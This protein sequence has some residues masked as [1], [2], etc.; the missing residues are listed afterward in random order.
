VPH[1]CILQYY[2]NS[3]S[4][5]VLPDVRVPLLAIN[6]GDDPIVRELP[7]PAHN[8][9]VALHV[10]AGGGHL[11]WFTS[12]PGGLFELQRWSTKPA[13]EWFKAVGE[14]MVIDER[15]VPE[16]FEEDGW[17]CERGREHLGL[18]AQDGWQK[19]IGVEGEGGPIPG[20]AQGL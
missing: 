19:V 18:K 20:L 17:L 10:T 4:D 8:G 12:A 1:L 7:E 16:L 3:S 14:E 15:K 6:A 11:G 13:L 9:W 5:Y 2:V